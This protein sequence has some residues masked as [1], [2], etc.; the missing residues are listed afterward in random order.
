MKNTHNNDIDTGE[1]IAGAERKTAT[2]QPQVSSRKIPE[3][4]Q[5]PYGRTRAA[6]YATGNQWAIE[7]FH[8]THN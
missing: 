7:N 2:T 8:A 6:V 1:H 3:R 4:K 5:T